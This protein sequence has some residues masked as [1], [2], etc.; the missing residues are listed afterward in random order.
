MKTTG[1]RDVTPCAK[2]SINQIT[3]LYILGYHNLQ[4]RKQLKEKERQH[5]GRGQCDRNTDG[6]HERI[7]LKLKLKETY[8]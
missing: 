6:K 8:G 4:L 5:S 7:K 3:W 2:T 1:L